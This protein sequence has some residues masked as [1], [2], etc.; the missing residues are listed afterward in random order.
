VID[1]AFLDHVADR[2]AG[3]AAVRAVALGG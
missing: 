3:L 2:L 1:S